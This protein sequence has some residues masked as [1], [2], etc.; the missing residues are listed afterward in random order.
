MAKMGRYCKAY[1]VDRFRAY[2]GWTENARNMR[3]EKEQGSGAEGGGEG[4]SSEGSS[5][6][7]ARD[8][9]FLQENYVVTDGIFLD[10][11]I[12]FD[13]TTPEWI[14]FCKNSL[15][16]EVP[17]AEDAAGAKSEQENASAGGR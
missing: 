15:G 2:S 7:P 12:I 13:H 8:Y 5:S 11:N 10:E 9:L 4:S 16:F 17:P 1:P 3:V 14:D 6:E